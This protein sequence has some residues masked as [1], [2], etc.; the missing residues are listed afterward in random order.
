MYIRCT[1]NASTTEHCRAVPIACLQDDMGG[2][3]LEVPPYEY[4]DNSSTID[5]LMKKGEGLLALLDESS[6]SEHASDRYFIGEKSG[7]RSPPK[8]TSGSKAPGS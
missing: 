2:D 4:V 8:H 7:D 3:G 1:E 6:L 5:M